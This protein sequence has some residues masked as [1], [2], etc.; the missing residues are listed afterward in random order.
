MVEG[1]GSRIRYSQQALWGLVNKPHFKSTYIAS[2]NF[3][4]LYWYL[5]V[6]ITIRKSGQKD[7]IFAILLSTL[8]AYNSSIE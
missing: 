7:L 2:I 1:Q 8:R 5:L 3:S 4:T 6:L